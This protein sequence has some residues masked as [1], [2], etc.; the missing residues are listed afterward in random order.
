MRGFNGGRRFF[1]GKQGIAF[2]GRAA[3]PDGRQIGRFA[4]V[5]AAGTLGPF[6]PV[7]EDRG[8]EQTAERPPPARKP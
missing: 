8:R 7:G 4:T 3:G 1:S 6:V 2:P 5:L